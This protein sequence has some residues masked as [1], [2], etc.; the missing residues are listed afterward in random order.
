VA[1]LQ[2]VLGLAC[3]A[4]IY[5]A[6][7]MASARQVAS[8]ALLLVLLRVAVAARADLRGQLRAARIPMLAV[9]CA[10]VVSLVRNDPLA[11]LATP[12]LVSFGLLCAFAGS[13]RGESVVERLARAQ[14][15]SLCDEEVLYCRRVTVVWCAFFLGNG[16][17][18]LWLAVAA[19]RAE[20]ALYTGLVSYLL[21]GSLYASEF[22]YRQWRFRRY[23]GAPSDALFR[24]IFP[25]RLG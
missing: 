4:L 23:L 8:A 7:R 12:S 14:G 6:L 21:L 5:L 3:P 13:L 17:L 25:P 10:G 15:V 16:A 1:A 2:L 9:A 20:W 22:V 19:T 11:L 24:R 18:A